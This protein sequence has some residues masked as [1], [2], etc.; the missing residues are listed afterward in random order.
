MQRG[1]SGDA[2]GGRGGLFEGL[3]G[4]A[5]G[6]EAE[7]FEVVGDGAAFEG[8]Y[9]EFGEVLGE[10]EAVASHSCEEAEFGVYYV[11]GFDIVAAPYCLEA[12]AGEAGNP[13]GEDVGD[14]FKEVLCAGL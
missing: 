1:C 7:F 14:Y 5:G 6:G 3:L 12:Y 10:H 2:A 9:V 13:I 11:A 4:E 8:V